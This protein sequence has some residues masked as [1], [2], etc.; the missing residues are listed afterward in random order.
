MAFEVEKIS[1]S[2]SGRI[3]IFFFLKVTGQN[4]FEI[5]TNRNFALKKIYLGNI[6]D[7]LRVFVKTQIMRFE[8]K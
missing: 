1:F 2:I 7:G 6:K 8:L 5:R 4:R 3:F